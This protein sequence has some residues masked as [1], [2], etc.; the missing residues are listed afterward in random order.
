MNIAYWILILLVVL[1]VILTI[2]VFI[3]L[4]VKSKEKKWIDEY[5]KEAIEVFKKANANKKMKIKYTYKV[6]T[7]KK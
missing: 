1:G 4:K 5:N 2:L 6:P 3:G 7:I